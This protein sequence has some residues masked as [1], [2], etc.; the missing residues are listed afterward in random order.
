MTKPTLE[1]FCIEKGLTIYEELSEFLDNE[2]G[3]NTFN[4]DEIEREFEQYLDD[5]YGDI[6]ICGLEYSAIHVLKQIDETAFR[7]GLNDWCD[8]EFVEISTSEYVRRE[9]YDDLEAEMEDHNTDVLEEYEYYLE[10][11]EE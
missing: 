10:E 3:H 5:H 8:S 7:T 11:F 2:T 4:D 9:D 6:D 1:Q